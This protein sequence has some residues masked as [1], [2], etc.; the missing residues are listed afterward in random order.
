VRDASAGW[1]GPLRPVVSGRSYTHTIT[2]A[3]ADFARF[4]SDRFRAVKVNRVE[5]M[6]GL[7]V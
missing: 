6:T 4:R 7:K 5:T 3:D 1:L 2:A